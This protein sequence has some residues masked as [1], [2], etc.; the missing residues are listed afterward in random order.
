MK[1]P[2]LRIGLGK[3]AREKNASVQTGI[4]CA[5]IV[6]VVILYF[7]ASQDFIPSVPSGL[8]YLIETAFSQFFKVEA[9]LIRTYERRSDSKVNLLASYSLET[10]YGTCV[11]ISDIPVICELSVP[12]S[13][14]IYKRC[15]IPFPTDFSVP[16]YEQN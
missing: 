11:I 5:D 3:I 13:L 8:P 6:N 9:R 15:N 16:P 14:Y 4:E 2:S 7:E 1:D 10:D 12:C